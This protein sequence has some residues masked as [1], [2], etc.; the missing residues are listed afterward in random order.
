MPQRPLLT[1]LLALGC[2]TAA[3]YPVATP[4]E[5]AAALPRLQPGDTVTLADGTWRDADLLCEATGTAEQPITFRAATP[6][7]VILTGVTRLRLSGRYVVVDGL[8]FQNALPPSQL[9]EFR[10]DSKQLAHHCRLT[11]CA[12]VDC[13]PPDDT[14][15]AKWLGLYGTDNRVDHCY[16]TGKTCGGTTLVVWVGDEPNR[17]RIDH[18]LFGPRPPLGR[19]GGETIRTGTSSVSMNESQTMV[20]ENLF[21]ECDGEVEIISNKS[22]GNVYRHNTFRRCSGALTL[23]HGNRCRV[24][25]NWFLGEGAKGSGG[26]RVIGEDHVVANNYFQG[27][28]GNGSRSAV[29]VMQ[30][31]VDSPLHGYFQVK[32]LLL[33]HNTFVNCRTSLEIGAKGKRTTLP[34]IDCRIVGNLFV[35]AEHPLVHQAVDPVGWHWIDNLYQATTLGIATLDGLASATGLLTEQPDGLWRPGPNS[36]AHGAAEALDATTEDIDGDPRQGRYTV[37]CDEPS[38]EAP[39]YRPL[40]EADVGPGYALPGR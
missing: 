34:P 26:V 3:E 22:C 24:D 10:R 23:R 19:N 8:V 35:S 37:G 36:P 18:N 27:L 16:L 12:I 20:E 7:Q 30:G 1:L 21:V 28:A 31:I 17:H 14:S 4:A 39:R 11:R 40:T 33:A 38:T 6:G 9:I 32:R 25:A 15:E 13:N 29:S 2:A 5:L